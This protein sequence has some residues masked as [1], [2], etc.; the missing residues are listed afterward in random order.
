MISLPPQV[1][2]ALSGELWHLFSVF[3]RVSAVV[4]VLP[5][6]GERSVPVRVKLGI[7]FAF[8]LIVAPLVPNMPP[9]LN[10]VGFSA[11]VGIEVLIGLSL[12][13]AIRFF[14]MALQVA[15]SIAAQ[16]TSLSQLLGSAAAEPV[17]AMGY[18]LMLAGLA[19]AAMAGLHIRVAEFLVQSYGV[20]PMGQL[21]TASGLS[22]WGVRRVARMFSL[23]FA[24]SAPFVIASLIYNLTLGVIN[25]AM[26]QL[27]VA[28]V[29]APVITFGGLALL[30]VG[31][32]LILSVWVDALMGFF[33]NPVGDQP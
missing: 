16:A 33:Q 23:A 25:R 7:A 6:F 10:P 3:L 26:P 24:L 4:S 28:F 18:L 29:G 11:L 12:G 5:A 31:A 15:G 8:S 30:M 32:P 9:P 2:N 27:M 17:P 20:F 13:I 14:V 21:P 1:L 19:L 22:E